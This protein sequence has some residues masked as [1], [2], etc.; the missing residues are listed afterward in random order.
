MLENPSH[1]PDPDRPVENVNWEDA[2]AFASK[3]N[4]R[5]S[6]SSGI[7]F[8]LPTEAEWEYAC[9]AGTSTAIYTG[10]LEILGYANAPALDAI[11]WY[12]GNSGHQYDL[13]KSVDVRNYEWLSDKQFPFTNAG[14]RRIKQKAPNPWGLYDML[15]NV[16]EWCS[17]RYAEK[18]VGAIVDPDGPET[19]PSRVIR[20]GSWLYIARYVRSSYRRRDDP[21]FRSHDLG[22]RLL[23]SASS[24]PVAERVSGSRRIPRDEA[25]ENQRTEGRG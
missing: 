11:A 25:E 14:T 17:D 24:G 19:G 8:R 23:S 1:F 16:W 10:P 18:L 4:E 6:E 12:G 5:L 15:G 3:M 2:N 9:R 20:G 7:Q 22:F 21:G 13:D